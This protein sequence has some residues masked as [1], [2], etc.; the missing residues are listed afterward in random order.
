ML[1]LIA[2]V[3]ILQRSFHV[4]S[5]PDHALLT[6]EATIQEYVIGQMFHDAF[7]APFNFTGSQSKDSHI[8][9]N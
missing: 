7:L 9:E 4:L 3:R 6:Q 1:P 8:I 5:S 2:E